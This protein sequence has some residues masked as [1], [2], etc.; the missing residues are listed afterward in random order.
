[1]AFMTMRNR[2]V[3]SVCHEVGVCPC[4]SVPQ[5]KVDFIFHLHRGPRLVLRGGFPRSGF[6]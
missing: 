5:K 6:S 1:M 4:D 3:T 2:H